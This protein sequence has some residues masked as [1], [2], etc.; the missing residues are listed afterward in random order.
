MDFLGGK[1]SILAAAGV[2]VTHMRVVRMPDGPS[3][4][5]AEKLQTKIQK[6]PGG[7]FQSEREALI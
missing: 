3:L 5:L 4:A 6:P 1:P 2:A 7:G